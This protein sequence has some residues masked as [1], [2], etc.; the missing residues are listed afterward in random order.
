VRHSDF[1]RLMDDEFG[2]A[3]ARSV[4]ADQVISALGGRTAVEALG[5][6][7]DPR[8]VWLA[9]CEAMS[10][11]QERRLGVDPADQGRRRAR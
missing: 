11:P 8:E 6:G 7:T 10:V 4:A 1:W 2:A 5:A 9:V 3:Y